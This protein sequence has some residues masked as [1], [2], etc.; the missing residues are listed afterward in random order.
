MLDPGDYS[1]TYEADAG[2]LSLD[3]ANTISNRNNEKTHDWLDSYGNLLSWGKLVGILSDGE[4]RILQREA[5]RSPELATDS[6]QLAVQLR[7]TSY[8]IFSAVAGGRSPAAKEIEALNAFLPQSLA[9]MEIVQGDGIFTWEWAGSEEDLDRII[10]PVARAVADLLTSRDLAR[11]GECLG[12]GC[13]WLFL[14][15]SRNR[16]RRWCSMGEC[17]NRA[18]A[19]RHYARSQS[20]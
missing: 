2:Y 11:V 13:G 9:H 3:F 4:S 5:E 18:K 8:R 6:L 17:G 15:M 10:W 20:A 1:G 12:D 7:E 16:S 19:R 14:D